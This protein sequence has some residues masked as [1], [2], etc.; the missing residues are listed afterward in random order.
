MCDLLEIA[1]SASES[2]LSEACD[3]EKTTKKEAEKVLDEDVE[4]LKTEPSSERRKSS[5]AATKSLHELKTAGNGS[6]KKGWFFSKV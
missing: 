3:D 5:L 4:D 1:K 2:S 6:G